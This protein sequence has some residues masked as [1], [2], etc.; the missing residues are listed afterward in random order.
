MLFGEVEASQVDLQPQPI[1]FLELTLELRLVARAPRRPGLSLRR[2]RLHPIQTLRVLDEDQ[3]V[4]PRLG[5]VPDDVEP[6][7]RPSGDERVALPLDDAQR[8]S[9]SSALDLDNPRVVAQY[10]DEVGA[11]GRGRD[12]AQTLRGPSVAEGRIPGARRSPPHLALVRTPPRQPSPDPLPLA[13]CPRTWGHRIS[14]ERHPL[15][16]NKRRCGPARCAPTRCRPFGVRRR[17]S[18]GDEGNRQHHQHHWRHG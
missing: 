18:N 10:G 4:R 17:V 11:G 1:D 16:R 15:R 7:S 2:A 12:D 14:R 6:R 3:V 8:T 9:R 5:G 13:F